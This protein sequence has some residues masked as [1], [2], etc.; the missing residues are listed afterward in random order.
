MDERTAAKL[1]PGPPRR[2]GAK[3]PSHRLV[4]RS[5]QAS[6]SSMFMHRRQG[7]SLAAFLADHLVS[8]SGSAS[9]RHKFSIKEV[10]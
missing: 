5:L 6:P 9:Q 7:P 10:V 3:R 1:A 2:A 4:L 8:D